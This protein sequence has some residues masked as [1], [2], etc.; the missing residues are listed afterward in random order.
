M[1]ELGVELFGTI[2]KLEA[3]AEFNCAFCNKDGLKTESGMIRSGDIFYFWNVFRKFLKHCDMQYYIPPK[4]RNAKTNGVEP[5]EFKENIKKYKMCSHCFDTISKFFLLPNLKI[6]EEINF[7]TR[8]LFWAYIAKSQMEYRCRCCESK[9]PIESSY[10]R[11]GNSREGC[12]CLSCYEA[13]APLLH[14]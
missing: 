3:A 12:V 9:I 2:K 6:D 14:I 5:W 11:F 13:I 7:E 8:S 1:P 10:V 4:L